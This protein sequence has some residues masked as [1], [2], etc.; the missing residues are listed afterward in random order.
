MAVLA[1]GRDVVAGGEKEAETPEVYFIP[2]SLNLIPIRLFNSPQRVLLS[3]IGVV[4]AADEVFTGLRAFCLCGDSREDLERISL[5]LE[6][7]NIRS[8]MMLT[9]ETSRIL[10]SVVSHCP[11]IEQE[12]IGGLKRSNPTD[13]PLREYESVLKGNMS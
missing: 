10:S 11:A 13:C 8:V 6:F 9:V 5:A 2:T 12:H 3:K 7:H 4:V 1:V